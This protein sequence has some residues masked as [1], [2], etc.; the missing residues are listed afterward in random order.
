MCGFAATILPSRMKWKSNVV[1]GDSLVPFSLWCLRAVSRCLFS[2]SIIC[3][4]PPVS[5]WCNSQNRMCLSLVQIYISTKLWK[6]VKGHQYSLY[7]PAP[8]NSLDN[9]LCTPAQSSMSAVCKCLNLSQDLKIAAPGNLEIYLDIT[10]S[11]K[12]WI[13]NCCVNCNW[14][15]WMYS[16]L[17]NYVL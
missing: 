3:A 13:K 14:A 9:F 6:L 1:S 16:K 8:V 15:C 17:R 10:V 4:L 11:W 2:C 7:F 5:F 12:W